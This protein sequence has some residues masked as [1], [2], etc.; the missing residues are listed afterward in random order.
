[1]ENIIKLKDLIKKENE[2][3]NVYRVKKGGLT[4]KKE[5]WRIGKYHESTS[6]LYGYYSRRDTSVKHVLD[7][8]RLDSKGRNYQSFHIGINKNK[9]D[10]SS[11][12]GEDIIDYWNSNEIFFLNMSEA[13]LTLMNR[14]KEKKR[15][16][17]KQEYE[18]QKV[19]SEA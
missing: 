13:Y 12:E 8:T 7:I 5:I 4:V 18:I 11:L 9:L 6:V 17:G 10:S 2:I 16:I 3:I 15:L 1:M 19:F 14:I